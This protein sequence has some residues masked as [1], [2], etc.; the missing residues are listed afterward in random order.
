MFLD[1]HISISRDTETMM[2]KVQLCITGMIDF[3]M[4]DDQK[5]VVLNCNNFTVLLLLLYFYDQII[6][7]LV[8][9]RLLSKHLKNLNYSKH[10]TGSLYILAVMTN[11]KLC[12]SAK[13]FSF[14]RSQQNLQTN[15]SH[16]LRTLCRSYC[17]VLNWIKLMCDLA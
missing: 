15:I 14:N 12:Q 1:Q 2:L 6:A 4:Y 5:T 7:A 13:L 8:T 10:L 9:R 16:W 17:W 3:K 11:Y